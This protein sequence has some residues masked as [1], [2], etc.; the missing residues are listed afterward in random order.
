M[1]LPNEKVGEEID[2][3]EKEVEVQL[4]TVK[5]AADKQSVQA[6]ETKNL[7][8]DKST[9]TEKFE[10]EKSVQ[11]ENFVENK[12]VQTEKFEEDIVLIPPRKENHFAEASTQTICKIICVYHVL[13]FNFF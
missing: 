12:S 3:N 6:E 8:E 1:Q 10:A 2:K 4:S 9:Q 7:I 5:S 11:T 13:L